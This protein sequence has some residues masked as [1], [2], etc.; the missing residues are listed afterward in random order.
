[1]ELGAPFTITQQHR[2][3]R[4]GELVDPVAAGTQQLVNESGRDA[5][6]ADAGGRNG[7]VGPDDFQLICALAAQGQGQ[8]CSRSSSTS[9]T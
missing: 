6:R 4:N 8:K 9:S 5:E 7:A 3:D 1:M 2:R